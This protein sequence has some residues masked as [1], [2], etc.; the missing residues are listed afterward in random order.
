MNDDGRQVVSV[1]LG[2]AAAFFLYATFTLPAISATA[3][4]VLTIA[5]G[6]GAWLYGPNTAPQP[7]TSVLVR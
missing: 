4:A 2:L 5:C 3:P 7:R 6:L 1:I